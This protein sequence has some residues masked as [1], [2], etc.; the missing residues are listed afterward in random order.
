MEK[1][2]KTTWLT[3]LLAILYYE[4]LWNLRKKKTVGLFILVFAHR[5]SGADAAS[6]ARLLSGQTTDAE[7]GRRV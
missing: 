7:S 3:G 4:F 6:F 5:D 2:R 1:Q